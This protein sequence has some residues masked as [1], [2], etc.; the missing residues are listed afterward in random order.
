[1]AVRLDAESL[2]RVWSAKAVGAWRLSA[3][4]AGLELDWW[5]GFSSAAALIGSP[6]QAAY[7][8]ANAYLDALAAWRR[9]QGMVATTINWG[10]WSRVGQAAQRSA[11]AVSPITP[12]EGIEALEALLAARIPAA[13]VLR[14]DRD[15]L[16]EAFPDLAE[17]PL[18]S[19][20]VGSDARSGT[21]AASAWPGVAA[22]DR[23]QAHARIQERVDERIAAVLGVESGRLDADA[24]LTT[25]GLDSLLAMR[26]RNA[27]QHDFDRLLPPSL[28]LRGASIND[29]VTWLC[30]ALDLSA[31]SPTAAAQEP[32]RRARV[33]PRDASE[34]LVA[35]AWE[36]VLGR[37]GFGVTDR[38]DEEDRDLA[39]ANRVSE[40]LSRRSGR[41]VSVDQLLA[42]PTIERQ[43]ALVREP[44]AASRSPLRL[45]H[46]GDVATSL[47]VFH[48][49]GGDTLVYR[50]LVEQLDPG[51]TVWG[52]D[53]LTGVSAVEQRAERYVELLRQAQSTGP[54]LLAGWSFGGA[55]AYETA[56]RLQAA[57]ERI[58]LVAMIDTIL[59]LPDPPGTS[60]VQV[61]ERRFQRF[62]RFLEDSYGKPLA[63]PYERMARLDD[64]A[65]SDLLIE[66]VVAAGLID[67]VAGG[68]IIEHQRTSYLDVRA[69]DRYRPGR[70]EGPVVLYSARDVQTDGMSDPR[71]DRRDPARGWDAVCG[72]QLEVVTVPGHHLSVLDP[73]NVDTL[74]S[75]LNQLLPGLVRAAA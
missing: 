41:P 44:D 32:V 68:A 38:C 40:L 69:L 31:P 57:G 30:E 63:L 64:E 70:I 14:L 36:E 37:S 4:T 8:A 51:L 17:I 72:K 61:L 23:S 11:D 50:Q 26:I 58:E 48:P 55:L 29:V 71:F 52:L 45:L 20:I 22:L 6:G 15:E 43:A 1:V 10:T 18:L 59:P 9:A 53:R 60:E 28:M 25:L 49:G 33:A 75:H 54:Y 67:P 3:A 12:T 65:Q 16:V 19:R 74:A 47:F 24:P 66:T 27:V 73:P 7:A 34:R 21:K 35:A 46:E 2:Q 39:A 56:R 42:N 62:A 13:G 5:V